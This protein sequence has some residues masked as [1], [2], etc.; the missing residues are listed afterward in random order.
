MHPPQ[1]VVDEIKRIHPQARL[2]W[3]GLE[4]KGSEEELNKGRFALIQLY[5][6]RDAA[7]TFLTPWANRGPVFGKHFDSLFWTPIYVIDVAAEDV[8]S[9]RIITM[10]KRWMRPMRERYVESAI[11]KGS[12]YQTQCDDIIGEA[13]DE[14]YSLAHRS[15]DGGAPVVAKKFLTLEEKKILSGDFDTNV[16]DTWLPENQTPVQA[17]SIS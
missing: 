17:E 10:L 4:R 8:F 16:K 15:T 5:H 2:G 14:M 12:E 3:E 11:A 9:G 6:A 13:A 7:K 1:W